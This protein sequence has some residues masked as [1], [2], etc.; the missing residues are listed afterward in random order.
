[1]IEF[2]TKMF[3]K[4]GNERHKYI[5]VILDELLISTAKP[6][7]V[8]VVPGI[9]YVNTQEDQPSKATAEWIVVTFAESWNL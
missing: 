7:F 8:T 9:F 6:S 4:F 5:I 3:P 2:P 1:M